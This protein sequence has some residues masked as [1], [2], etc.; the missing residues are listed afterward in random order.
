MKF[1]ELK[2][3]GEKN[4]IA[5]ENFVVFDNAEYVGGICAQSCSEYTRKQL[6]ELTDFIKKPQIGATGLIG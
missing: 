1:V 4:L 5:G 2:S 3:E 6:D